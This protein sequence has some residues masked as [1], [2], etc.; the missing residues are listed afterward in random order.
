MSLQSS[1]HFKSLR[2]ISDG[3]LLLLLQHKGTQQRIVICCKSCFVLTDGFNVPSDMRC[4][5][6]C[7]YDNCFLLHS[8]FYCNLH[9][10]L[11]IHVFFFYPWREVVQKYSQ[12]FIYLFMFFISF[13]RLTH[14]D[15]RTV[16]IIMHGTWSGATPLL[17]MVL[18]GLAQ[19]QDVPLV[20]GKTYYIA[21]HLSSHLLISDSDFVAALR[22]VFVCWS[23]GLSD[24][25]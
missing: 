24:C 1:Q 21:L 11:N 7:G 2:I 22:D 19:G 3:L 8:D 9:I 5:M 16:S 15:A 13:L 17:I 20:P 12:S 10:K 4:F 23:V 25:A 6:H 14:S 18:L